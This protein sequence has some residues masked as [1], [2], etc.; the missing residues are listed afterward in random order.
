MKTPPDTAQSRPPGYRLQTTFAGNDSGRKSW[1]DPRDERFQAWCACAYH[2]EV[3][4]DRCPIDW[5]CGIEG[6]V[7]GVVREFGE[8]GDSE[9]GDDRDA[10]SVSE[11]EPYWVVDLEKGWQGD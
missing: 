2:C 6:L 3:R 9:D 11:Q 4:F 7:I 5:Y 8:G 10:V 1:Y